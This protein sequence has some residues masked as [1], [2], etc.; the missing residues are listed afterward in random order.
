MKGFAWGLAVLFAL[1][2]VSATY[3]PQPGII[4]EYKGATCFS[5]GSMVLNLTHE[6]N[7]IAFKKIN[8]TVEGEKLAP[9]KLLGNWFIGVFPATNYEH[10]ADNYTGSNYLG[11]QRFKYKTLPNMYTE[12]E[13]IITLSWPSNTIY[14]D[15]IKFAVNCPGIPCTSNDQCIL[16]QACTNQTCEWI[17]CEE[18]DFAMGHTCLPKCNDYDPCTN[19]YFANEQCVFVKI[20]NCAVDAKGKIVAEPTN[21]FARFW[22]WLKSKY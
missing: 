12:G 2:L 15:K 7:N 18:S 19:D 4:F 16:Q 9:Q 8:L 5:D 20:G 14:Y 17:Q 21:I 22:N 13:Y 10:P 11:K 3:L 6:G 1:T